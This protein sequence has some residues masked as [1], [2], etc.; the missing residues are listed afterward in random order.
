MEDMGRISKS[1]TTPESWRALNGQGLYLLYA[2]P[3]S[4]MLAAVK[5]LEQAAGQ[6]PLSAAKAPGTLNARLRENNPV[7]IQPRPDAG[8]K[9]LP[10]EPI[11]TAA[12]ARPLPPTALSFPEAGILPESWF[13]RLSQP[14][15]QYLPKVRPGRALLWTYPEAGLDLGGKSSKARST[16][17]KKIIAALQL[18]AGSNNIWPH[19]SDPETSLPKERDYFFAGVSW[20]EPK[21]VLLFGPET[22]SAVNPEAV[23]KKYT[24]I[25]VQGRL[26]L[27]LPPLNALEEEQELAACLL[28]LTPFTKSISGAE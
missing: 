23:Y 5:A 20:L 13:S 26:H 4:A 18:P 21:F 9:D 17:I 7:K 2:P 1:L 8:I 25:S 16:L 22:L 10:P 19:R 6:P 11:A 14:W 15:L 24:F 28:F 12:T 3:G 27:L